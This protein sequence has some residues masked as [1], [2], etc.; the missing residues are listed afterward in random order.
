VVGLDVQERDGVYTLLQDGRAIVR[1]AVFG[2]VLMLSTDAAADLRKA[3]AAP[4]TPPPPGAAGG[5]TLRATAAA[6]GPVPALLRTGTVTGWA[7]AE[8]SGVSGELRPALR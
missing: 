7:R 6:L 4:A 1:A 2:R 3:A 5:L 8:P